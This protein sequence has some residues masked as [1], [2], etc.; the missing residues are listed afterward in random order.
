M[1]EGCEFRVQDSVFRVEGRT[2]FLAVS[3][4]PDSPRFRVQGAGCR[5]QGAGC[6]VEG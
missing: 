6:R 5:V 3:S 2:A 1:R 4:I